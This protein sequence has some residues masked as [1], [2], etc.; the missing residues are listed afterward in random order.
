MQTKPGTWLRSAAAA[1][2]QRRMPTDT[3]VSGLGASHVVCTVIKSFYTTAGGRQGCHCPSALRLLDCT[4]SRAVAPHRS[5]QRKLVRARGSG[6]AAA[7]PRL[8]HQTLPPLAPPPRP[9]PTSME[10]Q[11]VRLGKG[12]PEIASPLGMGLWSW[13]DSYVSQGVVCVGER[14]GL[15]SKRHWVLGAKPSC[16]SSASLLLKQRQLPSSIESPF[17]PTACRPGGTAGTMQP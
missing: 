14:D 15:G 6:K 17:P 10:E 12:G 11:P 4:A 9:P 3:V 16:P 7:S 1:Q 5:P 8:A 2:R 13:G